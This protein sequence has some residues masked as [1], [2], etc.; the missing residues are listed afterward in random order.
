MKPDKWMQGMESEVEH[1]ADAIW[2]HETRQ[3]VQREKWKQVGLTAFATL[4]VF[5]LTTLIPVGFYLLGV[6]SSTVYS[7]VM[8][9][10]EFVLFVSLVMWLGRRR[11]PL[12]PMLVG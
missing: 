2:A 6:R 11:L 7:V 3:A 4:L 9:N 5:Q 8:D 12:W 10:Q 1:A